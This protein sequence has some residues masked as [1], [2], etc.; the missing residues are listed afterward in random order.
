L[1]EVTE[2][3]I[4]TNEMLLLEKLPGVVNY[5]LRK[6]IINVWEKCSV[7]YITAFVYHFVSIG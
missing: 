3:G 6:R 2:K 4:K 1:F 5:N 7:L